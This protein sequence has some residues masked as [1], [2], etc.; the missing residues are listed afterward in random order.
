MEELE[1]KQCLF[2]SDEDFEQL[3]KLQDIV[4]QSRG[5]KF[6]VDRFK[7]WYI[8]N[9]CGRVISFNA[10]DGNKMVA[11]YACMSCTEKS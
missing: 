1:L 4:Y 10:Y 7:M 8:N 5:I 2:D 6:S 3:V 11:H 9:P